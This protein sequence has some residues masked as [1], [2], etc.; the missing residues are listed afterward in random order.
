MSL[1]FLFLLTS[2]PGVFAQAFDPAQILQ[3]PQSYDGKRLTAS[4][5]VRHVFAQTTRQG[6]DYT[7]FDL[8][9]DVCMKVF[10]W[11]HPRLRV[12]QRQSV[13]GKFETMKRV[14]A[15][16]FENVLETQEGSIR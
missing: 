12:N 14:E 4:G 8:C 11:G 2:N 1:M 9:D 3:H 16:T 5:T 10:V 15:Q 6:K 7:T 13:S